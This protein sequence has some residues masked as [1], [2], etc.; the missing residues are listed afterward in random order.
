[1]VYV[2]TKTEL[3]GPI[4]PSVVYDEN[5]IEPQRNQ[6]YKRSLCRIWN[7]TVKNY[8]IRCGMLPKLNKTMT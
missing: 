5:Q 1:M 3:L 7:W 6:L 2:E 8:W 4:W